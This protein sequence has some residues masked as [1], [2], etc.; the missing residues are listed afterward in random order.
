M[1]TTVSHMGRGIYFTGTE[2]KFGY[3][4]NKGTKNLEN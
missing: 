2:E 4:R 1:N 3:Q